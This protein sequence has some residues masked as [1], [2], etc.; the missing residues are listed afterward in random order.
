M[1]S[2]CCARL[3]EGR[4]AAAGPSGKAS[5]VG[6]AHSRRSGVTGGRAGLCGGAAGGDGPARVFI[7]LSLHAVLRTRFSSK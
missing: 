6:E 2:R 5:W 7:N 1:G 3:E 4:V